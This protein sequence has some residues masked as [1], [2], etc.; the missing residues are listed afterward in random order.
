MGFLK[1]LFGGKHEPGASEQP[2]AVSKIARPKISDNPAVQSNDLNRYIADRLLRERSLDVHSAFQ[3]KFESIRIGRNAYR[4]PAWGHSLYTGQLCELFMLCLTAR[5]LGC[6]EETPIAEKWFGEDIPF[7]KES[8]SH[9]FT[10]R[11]SSGRELLYETKFLQLLNQMRSESDELD[12]D[13]GPFH[14]DFF[15]Y[16]YAPEQ[17][18]LSP[19][20]CPEFNRNLPLDPEVE[21]ILVELLSDVWS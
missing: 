3:L 1:K 13:S 6:A 20:S 16:H 19:G 5:A 17:E 18:L 8:T 4:Q 9:Y 11:I 7:L 14:F 21:A 10:D 2:S 15:P 12:Y